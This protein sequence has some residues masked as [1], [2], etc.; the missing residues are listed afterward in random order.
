M[1][2]HF[3]SFRILEVILTLQIFK[4][5][6]T[7]ERDYL[8][9]I[10]FFCFMYT[11]VNACTCMNLESRIVI[12][13]SNL[14]LQFGQEMKRNIKVKFIKLQLIKQSTVRPISIKPSTFL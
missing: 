2:F 12:L 14:M 7:C 3:N 11:Y 10:Y 9:G 8:N 13:V 5:N 1:P 6:I 4:L